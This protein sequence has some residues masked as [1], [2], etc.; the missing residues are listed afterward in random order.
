MENDVCSSALQDGV[1]FEIP[2]FRKELV[3]KRYENDK[4]SPW[5]VP[6]QPPPSIKGFITPS[7][8]AIAYARQAWEEMGELSHKVK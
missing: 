6:G 2:D 5:P 1:P 3:R 7:E 8:D 4:W